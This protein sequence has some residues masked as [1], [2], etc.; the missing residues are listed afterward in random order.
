MSL[1]NDVLQG[2]EKRHASEAELQTLPPY[3]RAIPARPQSPVRMYLVAAVFL[4]LVVVGAF[5]VAGG[6]L[7]P[8]D[9]AQ[10]IAAKPIAV[11]APA[12]VPVPAV[13]VMPP[14]A[15]LQRNRQRSI[16]SPGFRMN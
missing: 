5:Y 1:I 6:R 3:V 7:E 2:L 8:E 4:S 10:Q 15:G 12:P 14:V 13:P 9:H 11:P 16:L